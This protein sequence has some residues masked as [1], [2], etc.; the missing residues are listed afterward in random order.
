[1]RRLSID[2]PYTGDWF[3]VAFITWTDPNNDRIEQQGNK[4]QSTEIVT[5]AR[6]KRANRRTSFPSDV[7]K[8]LLAMTQQQ[9]GFEKRPTTEQFE[10]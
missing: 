6:R 4:I 1:M 7:V 8:M 2:G 9:I 3:A 5:A 10:N